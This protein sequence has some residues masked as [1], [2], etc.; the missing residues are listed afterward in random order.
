MR[1][2]LMTTVILLFNLVIGT[3]T[4]LSFQQMWVSSFDAKLKADKTASS[5]TLAV[6]KV[7]DALTV[8][9]EEGRWYRVTTTDRKKGWI[10]RG[11]VSSEP[12]R[13]AGEN[14]DGDSV[15]KLLTGLTGT[16]IGSGEVDTSRSMRMLSVE[17]KKKKASGP[18]QEYEAALESVLS[19]RIPYARVDQF[20]Q[21]GKIG[22][23]AP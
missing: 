11:K 4:G 2:Q 23:Y 18:E 22:E 21:N 1:V 12:P 3:A 20:L 10:Y 16:R 15:G 13:A 7:G 8:Q 9:S 17:D 19:R 6:L 5:E 14:G